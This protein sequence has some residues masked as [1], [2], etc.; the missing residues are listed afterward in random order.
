[1]NISLKRVTSL[2]VATALIF[3]GVYSVDSPYLPV[4]QA[5]EDGAGDP[6]YSTDTALDADAITSGTVKNLSLIHI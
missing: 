4:A 1:M 3:S 2:G 6:G 5:A